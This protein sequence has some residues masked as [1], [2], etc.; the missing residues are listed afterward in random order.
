MGGVDR[1]P[2]ASPERGA[3][4]RTAVAEAAELPGI[5][6]E[7]VRGRIR[8]GTLPVGRGGGAVYVLLEPAAAER[9]NDDQPRTTG[10]RPSDRTDALI[11][12]LEGQVEDLREQHQPRDAVS[13]RIRPGVGRHKRQDDP[14]KD[15]HRGGSERPDAQDFGEGVLF[16]LSHSRPSS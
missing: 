5:S 10:V 14:A 8:R 6:V 4:R 1:G 16:V 2:Y 9:T 3:R 15:A 11:S 12:T 7:A 13:E